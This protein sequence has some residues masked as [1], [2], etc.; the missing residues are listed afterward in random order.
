MKKIYTI[1]LLLV[2]QCLTLRG[3][4]KPNLLL[5]P[6]EKSGKKETATYAEMI[7][8]YKTL[9]SAFDNIRMLEIGNTDGMYPLHVV[10]YA[11]Q[12]DFKTGKLEK[13]EKIVVLVNNG[14]H[15]GEP[16]GVDASMMMMRDAALG[17]II[18]P[19]NVIVAVIPAYNIGGM[20]NRGHN[21]RA[22]QNGPVSYGFRGNSQNLDLNRDFM[23]CDALETRALEQLFTKLDPEVFIDNHVSDG[24]DYQHVV[25]LIPTQHDKLGGKTGEFLHQT[26]TPLIYENMKQIV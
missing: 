25:T 10:Y 6:F 4:E 16:D 24:A 7:E 18:I 20:L 14:I 21:S 9:D 19:S 13:G 23:K 17:K 12:S 15:A 2:S 22:N 1:L 3:A 5:T 11:P 26:L 8:F